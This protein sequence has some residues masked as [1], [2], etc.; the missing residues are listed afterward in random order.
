MKQTHP[1]DDFKQIKGIGPATERRLHEAGIHTYE[2]LASTEADAL[3]KIGAGLVGMSP[4]RVIQEDWRGQAQELAQKHS[5]SANGQHYA[6]FTVELLLDQ[7]NG[8]RRTR[9]VH[10]QDD[11]HK[12]TWAG[13]EDQRLVQFITGHAGL[14]TA[15]KVE[16]TEAAANAET[17][18]TKPTNFNIEPVDELLM[19]FT[20]TQPTAHT[21]QQEQPQVRASVAQTNEPSPQ[22]VQETVT[23]A[24]TKTVFEHGRFFDVQLQLDLSQ[25][26]HAQNTPLR[27]QSAIFAV[28]MVAGARAKIGATQGS[29]EAIQ[30]EF[31][32]QIPAQIQ[33]PGTY[34]LEAEMN[35]SWLPSTSDLSTAAKGTLV[36]IY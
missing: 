9:V 30:D 16:Q 26:D 10:V 35:L 21:P 23:V 33:S 12:E 19:V 1:P 2:Q 11:A 8:V 36:H 31:A 29:I 15:V 27:Y 32:L 14:K 18:Q 3:A 34:R 20:K 28:D 4:E 22:A 6:T 25:I 13:W 5:P 17:A 24:T 7:D